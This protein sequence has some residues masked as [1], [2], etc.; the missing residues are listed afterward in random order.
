MARTIGVLLVVMKEAY[1]LGECGAL[2]LGKQ[3]D[4][5]SAALSV[6]DK[7]PMISDCTKYK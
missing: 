5:H 3:E 1:V 2:I 6:Q 4:S 7:G